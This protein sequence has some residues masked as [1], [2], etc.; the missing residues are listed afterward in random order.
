M[1]PAQPE[2]AEERTA[3]H[4]RLCAELA[5]LGMQLARAAAAKALAEWAEPEQ[6]PTAEPQSDQPTALPNQPAEPPPEPAPT[7]KRTAGSA[8]TRKPT[9][10]ALLFTRLVAAVRDC[11]ALEARLAAATSP[12]AARALSLQL[13]ADPR[14]AHLRDAFRLVTENHPDRAELLRETTTRLDEELAADEG[15]SIDP[16]T[17][18]FAICEEL[19]IEI[20]FATLPDQY[21]DFAPEL[22]AT[23]PPED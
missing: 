1:P 19:G 15:R 23:S 10:P 5:D 2:Q 20:D 17:L 21:L 3:R 12:A 16:P 7:P 11:I 8:A 14:R 13:R 9:D 22:H 6:P 18:F 4:L